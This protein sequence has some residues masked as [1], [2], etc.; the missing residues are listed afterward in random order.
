ML[1]DRGLHVVDVLCMDPCPLLV[2]LIHQ[3]CIRVYAG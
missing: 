2:L 1:A 3:V